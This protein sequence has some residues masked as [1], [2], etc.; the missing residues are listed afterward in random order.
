MLRGGTHEVRPETLTK[1]SVTV[2]LEYHFK[3]CKQCRSV[4]HGMAYMP[5]FPF[6]CPQQTLLI[7]HIDLC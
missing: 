1:G 7:K 5:V 6:L 2:F 4:T 3:A